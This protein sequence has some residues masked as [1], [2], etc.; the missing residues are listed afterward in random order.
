MDIRTLQYFVTIVECG[1][2]SIAAKKIHMTQPPLS[3][4][5]KNLEEEL[6]TILMERGPRSITLTDAGKNYMSMPNP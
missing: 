1:N 5:I 4:Q 3:K 6:G 2:I